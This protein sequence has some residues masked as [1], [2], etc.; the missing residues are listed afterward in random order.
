[1]ARVIALKWAAKC[2]DC[3]AELPAG[4]KAKFYGRGKIYGIGC[5]SPSGTKAAN[6]TPNP[7]PYGSA[8]ERG[9]SSPGAIASHYD[10]IGVYAMDGTKL[11]STCRC[12]DYPCCGH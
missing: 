2:S 11:G 4:T 12:I 10:P 3:G 5:H 1:M 7:A 6:W 8:Y 9:D